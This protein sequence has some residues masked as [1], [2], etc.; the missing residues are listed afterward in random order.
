MFDKIKFRL[1]VLSFHW[2][3]LHMPRSYKADTADELKEDLKY[4]RR[5]ALYCM[6]LV[7]TALGLLA[8]EILFMDALYVFF[9]GFFT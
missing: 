6:V 1:A 3:N 4:A 2:I 7:A 8:L 9:K 5:P